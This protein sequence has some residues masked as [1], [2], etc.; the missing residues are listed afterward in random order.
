MYQPAYF[1]EEDSSQ[2][3]EFI[4]RHPFGVL[5]SGG[6]LVASH[7]PIMVSDDQ[8]LLYTH[9][10]EMNP[11][12]HLDVGTEALAIF[13]GPHAYI[14][15][16][17]YNSSQSVPTWNYLAV[18]VKARIIELDRDRS[19]EILMQ[20][21]DHIEPDYREQW[22]EISS[23]YKS[24]LI[25]EMRPLGM[26]IISVQMT[27]KISQNK[28]QAERKRIADYLLSTDNSNARQIAAEMQK[29]L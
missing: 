24:A 17:H 19:E 13:H 9:V 18:H 29:S 7:L 21:V 12:A 28:S 16:K 10:A 23:Q 4:E 8:T 1:K 20:L 11:L 25:N 14:S 27:K 15:P 26:E 5:V 3:F 2:A 22:Q 6:S